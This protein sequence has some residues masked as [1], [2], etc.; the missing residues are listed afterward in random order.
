MDAGR[1]AGP[2]RAEEDAQCEISEGE[3]RERE[4]KAEAGDPQQDADLVR[5]GVIDTI[6]ILGA[7]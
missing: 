5:N 1:R 3:I 2:D 4:E 7:G 6:F